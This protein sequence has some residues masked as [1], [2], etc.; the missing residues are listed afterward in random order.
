MKR[1][2]MRRKSPTP[3]P[4]KIRFQVLARDGYRC[5]WCRSAGP[6]ELHHV[7]KRSQGRD[8][9]PENLLTLCRFCHERTDRPYRKGRLVVTPLPG[10]NFSLEVV[11]KLDKFAPDPA[12]S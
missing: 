12:A 3:I 6:L 5:R 2:R 11:T 8:D 1:T 9:K 4:A 7:R 10:G